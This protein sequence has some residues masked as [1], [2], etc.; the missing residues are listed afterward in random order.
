[1][2]MSLVQEGSGFPYI[3]PP[4]YKYL[5]SAE[6]STIEPTVDDVQNLEATSFIEKVQNIADC[7][8]KLCFRP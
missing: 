7:K 1:M 8:R 4:V 3:A 2:A 5:C 6:F